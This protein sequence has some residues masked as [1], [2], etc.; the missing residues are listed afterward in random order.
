ME[1][2]SHIDLDSPI[3]PAILSGLFGLSIPMV[4][5]ANKDGKLPPT[6]IKDITYREAITHYIRYWKTKSN[7]K[8]SELLDRKTLQEIRLGIAKEE[9]Q[10]L[11]IKRER[12]LLIDREEFI[13]VMSPIFGII[14]SGLVNLTREFPETQSKI[15]TLLKTWQQMG[16]QILQE[17]KEDGSNFVQKM[18]EAEV[19]LSETDND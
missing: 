6:P 5:Q 15:D 12:E 18:L 9:A 14:K 1:N 19:E 11:A 4:Y 3:S 17:A 13:Q 7:L 10:W 16:D 8:V 2:T